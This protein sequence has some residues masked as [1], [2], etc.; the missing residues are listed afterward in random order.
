M[1]SQT[2]D[3]APLLDRL[4]RR[5]AE[6]PD[7]FLAEPMIGRTGRIHTD[8]VVN[9]LLRDLGGGCPEAGDLDSFRRTDK[10]ARNRLRLVLVGS[11][12][13]HDDYFINRKSLAAPAILWLRNGLNDL[14][15]IIAADLFVSDPDR[16]EEL[17]RLCLAALNL[18]PAGETAAQAEDRLKTLNSVERIHIIRDTQKKRQ[19]ARQLLEEM[20][21]K[22]AQEAAAKAGREW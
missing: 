9:D 17:A 22:E 6:C 10:S 1:N 7:V 5:L 15:E 2:P 11:W 21:R 3:Q 13:L 8:A 4:T 12:L 19:R 16:R 14:S 20:R 18:F